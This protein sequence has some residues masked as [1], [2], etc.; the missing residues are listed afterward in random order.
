MRT[1]F[2]GLLCLS[3]ALCASAAMAQAKLR[4]WNIHPDGYP[5]SEAMKSFVEQVAKST[6]GRYNI[7]LFNSGTLGDQPKAVQMLKSG[8]IDVA[9][10]SS[11]PLSDAVPG[12]KV[13]NLPFLFTDSAHMFRHLDGKLGE[14]F[15]A[16]LK[17]AGFVVLGWYDGGGR[18][19]YCV[20]PVNN[21]RDLAGMNI[22]VQQSEVYIEMVKLMEA[23]PVALPFKEV[24]GALEQS[25]VDCAENNLPS[26]ESTGHYKVAKNVYVT[27]HVISP[28]ALVVSTKLWDKLSKEDKAAFAEAGAKSAILMRELWNKRVAAALEATTKQ[29]SQFVKVRDASPMVRRMGPLYGKYMADPTTREELLTIIAK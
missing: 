13:L 22:R 9:E 19:F 18:S 12:I 20:K 24:L 1:S 8:E 23:K 2:K 4:A 28:E 21:L 14:R 3:F 6:G 5:V 16:N 15:S 29:G 25:K 11:G 10:F 17:A 27:N 26:Y 7:E